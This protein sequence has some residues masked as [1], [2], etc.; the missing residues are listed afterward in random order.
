TSFRSINAYTYAK[1][2]SIKKQQKSTQIS[3][4]AQV[5]ESTSSHQTSLSSKI[6]RSRQT[7]RTITEAKKNIL[8]QLFKVRERM[9]DAIIS[10]VTLEL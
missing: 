5:Q 3:N 10:K 8:L 2:E 9:P 1:L 6:N 4:S 7:Y